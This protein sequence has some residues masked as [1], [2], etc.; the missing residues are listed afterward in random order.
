MKKGINEIS[1]I[2]IKESFFSPEVFRVTM[3]WHAELNI[4]GIVTYRI[5]DGSRK[6]TNISR[7]VVP[8][9]EMQKF[10][11]EIYEF[12]RTA[13]SCANYIDD[14]SRVVTLVY[15]PGHKEILEGCPVRNGKQMLAFI[16]SFMVNHGVKDD[17]IS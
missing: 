13:D 3:S 16:Y 11:S 6:R 12:V 14:C 10:F 4:D 8:T 9:T 1:Q 15:A 5:N 2:K 7:T 17:W